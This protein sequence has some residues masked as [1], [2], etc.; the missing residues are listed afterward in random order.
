[1]L[2]CV[3]KLANGLRNPCKWFEKFWC[4]ISGQKLGRKKPVRSGHPIRQVFFCFMWG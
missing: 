2:S 1:L 4:R 3:C